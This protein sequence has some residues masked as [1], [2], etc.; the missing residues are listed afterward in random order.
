MVLT[1]YA[2]FASYYSVILAF[3]NVLVLL[4]ESIDSKVG[5]LL[6]LLIVLLLVLMWEFIS[7]FFLVIFYIILTSF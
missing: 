1:S 2:I 3:C 7:L 4:S 5:L 6:V